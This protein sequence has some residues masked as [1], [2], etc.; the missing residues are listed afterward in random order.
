MHIDPTEER[1]ERPAGKSRSQVS[2]RCPNFRQMSETLLC[3]C[4]II[5]NI[6]IYYI[7]CMRIKQISRF[8]Q[9][10]STLK[11]LKMSISNCFCGWRQCQCWFDWLTDDSW[12]WGRELTSREVRM[13]P[14]FEDFF[15]RLMD[16][17]MDKSDR[18]V[19]E[20]VTLNVY[21]MFWTNTYTDR[22]GIGVY[23]SGI[24][25]SITSYFSGPD[26]IASF[27]YT[28]GSLRP[29]ICVWWPPVFLLGDL[30]YWAET[31][32]PSSPSP[33]KPFCCCW[34]MICVIT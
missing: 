9:N 13:E 27:L 34:L 7:W 22:I 24:V 6:D 10:K 12:L 4:K 28:V 23:H 26:L 33:Y 31:G 30:W 25:R 11:Q 14:P 2:I 29:G 20:P 18:R 32:D 19:L 17:M 21:D 16:K 8:I 15:D 3:N 1:V 5:E